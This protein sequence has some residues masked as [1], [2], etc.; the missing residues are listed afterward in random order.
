MRKIITL[1]TFLLISIASIG[2]LPIGKNKNSG[3]KEFIALLKSNGY[4]YLNESV[5]HLYGYNKETKKWD[6]PSEEYIEILFKEEFTVNIYY[7]KYDNIRSIAIDFENEKNKKKL[8]SIFNYN[9]WKLIRENAK[10]KEMT[11]RVGDFYAL[12]SEV[13]IIISLNDFKN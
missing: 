5:Q 13:Q 12:V 3:K 8:L 2:Q 10:Y 7:N 1:I 9:K 11:F 4:H 6:V